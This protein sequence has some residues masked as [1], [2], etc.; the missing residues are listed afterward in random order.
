MHRRRGIAFND[1]PLAAVKSRRAQLVARVLNAPPAPH[2][3][4]TVFGRPVLGLGFRPEQ[5]PRANS[6]PVTH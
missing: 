6:V 5:P 1:K 4:A 3:F 2:R